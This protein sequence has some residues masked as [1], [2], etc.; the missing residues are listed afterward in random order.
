M[1]RPPVAD[2]TTHKGPGGRTVANPTGPVL[3]R[4]GVALAQRPGFGQ[5]CR[6]QLGNGFVGFTEFG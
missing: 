2:L 1:L 4:F 6:I 3:G 5:H